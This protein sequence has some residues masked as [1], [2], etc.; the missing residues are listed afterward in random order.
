MPLGGGPVYQPTTV[1]YE[2][3]SGGNGLASGGLGGGLGGVGAGGVG[4]GGLHFLGPVSSNL[5]V[6]SPL[7]MLRKPRPQLAFLFC[8]ILVLITGLAMVVSSLVDWMDTVSPF[9]TIND[10][11]NTEIVTHSEVTQE[12]TTQTKARDDPLA[13]QNLPLGVLL[14]GIFLL[15]LGVIGMG[16]EL[17]SLL[18]LQFLLNFVV[19]L[20]DLQAI[21]WR[22][23]GWRRT[24]VCPCPFFGQKQSLARQMQCHGGAGVGGG[25]HIGSGSGCSHHGTMA[26]N[27]STDPLVSHTQ[28]AA[29][30]ELPS[31]R[32]DEEE[33]RNLMHDNKDW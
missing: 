23:S 22:L 18:S 2:P 1:S 19:Y 3:R 17:W 16:K 12:H 33:R 26:M 13:D 25:V 10:H 4:G 9:D 8:V 28:Y 14:G 11:K 31:L 29:V 27:P 5:G 24:C 30:S 6:D 15:I 20:F 21:Y 7:R 32:S